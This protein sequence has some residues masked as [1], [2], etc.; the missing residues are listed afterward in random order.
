MLRF[1]KAVINGQVVRSIEMAAD[2]KRQYGLVQIGLKHSTLL[3][4]LQLPLIEVGNAARACCYSTD[5][6]PQTFQQRFRY[7]GLG[8]LRKASREQVLRSLTGA[9]HLG[10]ITVCRTLRL[11]SNFIGVHCIRK[12][13]QMYLL[14]V[15]STIGIAIGCR[16][17]QGIAIGK[18]LPYATQFCRTAN[19]PP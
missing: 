4:L 8:R 3:T 17:Q 11:V 2:R 16:L 15:R 1:V 18:P 19:M 7:L 6:Y 5:S 14:L 12:A 13:I 9:Q 10:R